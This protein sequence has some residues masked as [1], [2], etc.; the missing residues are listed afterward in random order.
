MLCLYACLGLCAR[1][2][3]VSWWILQ[4]L[5]LSEFK[6]NPDLLLDLNCLSIKRKIRLIS[7]DIA[8]SIKRATCGIVSSLDDNFMSSSV[9]FVTYYGISEI[10]IHAFSNT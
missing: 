2:S 6:E 10:V 9:P 1:R 3:G 4:E 8:R 7:Q 5:L